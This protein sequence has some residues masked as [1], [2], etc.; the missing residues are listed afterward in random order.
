M[1]LQKCLTFGVHII[2]RKIIIFLQ[3]SGTRKSD[4]DMLF[5]LRA[6]I[7]KP[8][9]ESKKQIGRIADADGKTSVYRGGIAQ[10]QF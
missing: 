2:K 5:Y 8:H 1:H 10:R 4:A 3:I 6:R 9:S 7:E